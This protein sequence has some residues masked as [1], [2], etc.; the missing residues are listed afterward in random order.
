MVTQFEPQDAAV[1]APLEH[2]RWVLEHQNMGWH[3]GDEYETI[4]LPEEVELSKDEE[5]KYRKALR[6]QMRHHK[7]TMD[8]EVTAE[9]IKQHYLS[10]SEEEQDKDW[11]PF[12]SMLALLKKYDGLRIYRL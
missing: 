9:L 11:K 7:L 8:G 10:L 5:K 6:E 3:F 4:S 12:N 1:F 2:E